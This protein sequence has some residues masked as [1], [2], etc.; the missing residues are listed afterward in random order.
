VAFGDASQGREIVTTHGR[1]LRRCRTLPRTE[2]RFFRPG[3][4]PPP[5]AL[6]GLCHNSWVI[7]TVLTLPLTQHVDSISVVTYWNR[8][9]KERIDIPDEAIAEFNQKLEQGQ[10]KTQQLMLATVIEIRDLEV[11]RGAFFSLKFQ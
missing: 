6:L 8:E 1:R 5:G 11:G 3:G 9:E 7:N 10:D 2:L 4:S